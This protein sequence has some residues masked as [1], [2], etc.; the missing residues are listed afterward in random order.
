MRD[1]RPLAFW[2]KLSIVKDIGEQS[3]RGH[4]D[5]HLHMEKACGLSMELPN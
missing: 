1:E 5:T 2:L 4:M 3:D